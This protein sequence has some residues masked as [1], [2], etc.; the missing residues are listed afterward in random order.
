MQSF[1]ADD[2]LEQHVE[3][4][5]PERIEAEQLEIARARATTEDR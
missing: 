3:K 2:E 4:W 1:F 5:P